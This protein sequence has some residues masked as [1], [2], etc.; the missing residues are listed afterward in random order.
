[1]RGSVVLSLMA[2]GLQ[3]VASCARC[4]LMV[5][6]ETVPG[7]LI[8][9]TLPCSEAEPHSKGED[10]GHWSP[11]LSDSGNFVS[12]IVTQHLALRCARRG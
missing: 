5:L 7:F 8:G 1:M 3:L 11:T 9:D 4:C 6:S 2:L 10:F 12:S